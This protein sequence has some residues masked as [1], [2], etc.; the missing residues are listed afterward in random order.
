MAL[1]MEMERM[2]NGSGKGYHNF[3][4]NYL[5]VSFVSL[6]D[7]VLVCYSHIQ[8]LNSSLSLGLVGDEIR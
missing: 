8:D 3:S 7:L 6:C 5:H 4:F 2:H 1:A